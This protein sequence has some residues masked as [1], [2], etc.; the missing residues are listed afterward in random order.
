MSLHFDIAYN[1]RTSCSVRKKI[2][3]EYQGSGHKYIILG[4]INY[5]NFEI[6]LN[7]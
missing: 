7:T 4:L 5:L 6:L 2:T 3:P 1:S